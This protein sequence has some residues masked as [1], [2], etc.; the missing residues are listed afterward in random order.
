MRLLTVP[1]APADGRVVNRA[2]LGLR[3]AVRLALLLAQHNRRGPRRD[4]LRQLLR[5]RHLVVPVLPGWPVELRCGGPDTH[6]ARLHAAKRRP[7]RE[8]RNAAGRA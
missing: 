6:D 5:R 3:V 2:G 8:R 7:I 1:R 4:V